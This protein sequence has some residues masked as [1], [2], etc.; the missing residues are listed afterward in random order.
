MEKPEEV[1]AKHPFFEG[2]DPSLLKVFSSCASYVRYEAGQMIYKEGDEANQALLIQDGR[3]AIEIFAAQ[4][5]PLI[6]ETLRFGDVI[7]WSFLFPPYRRRFDARAIEPTT[8]IALDGKSLRKKG[9]EDPR[10]GCE[11]L[12]RFSVIIVERLQATR[13]QLLDVY[14]KHA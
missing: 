13:L 11:L 4:R 7:G 1:L 8:A 12:K 3:V 2:L 5:G 10:F 9:E 14:G 6:I